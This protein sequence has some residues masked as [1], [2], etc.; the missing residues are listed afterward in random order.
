M[1]TEP[2]SVEPDHDAAHERAD[3]ARYAERHA[4]I[5][6][7]LRAHF[8]ALRRVPRGVRVPELALIDYALAPIAAI[9]TWPPLDVTDE[10]VAEHTD[11]YGVPALLRALATAIELE[12]R[13]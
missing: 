5:V 9:T 4:V 10:D 6:E 11:T 12:A 1:R 7:R 8:A 2:Y 13:A 3:D